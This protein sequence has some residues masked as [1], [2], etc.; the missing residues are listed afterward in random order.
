VNPFSCAA[1]PSKDEIIAILK[2]Q[3]AASQEREEVL[4]KTNLALVDARAAAQVYR[5]PRPVEEPQ[6]P[7]SDPT[8][9]WGSMETFVPKKPPTKEE[10]EALFQQ[11]SGV[12]PAG[13]MS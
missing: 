9:S 2:E 7:S 6:K 12:H 10:I 8:Q 1:C 11:P 4:Q 3:L 13:R 5:K